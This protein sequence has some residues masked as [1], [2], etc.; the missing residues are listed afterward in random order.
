M[1][2]PDS[3]MT[4][5]ACRAQAWGRVCASVQVG[6][7]VVYLYYRRGIILCQRQQDGDTGG[8]VLAGAQGPHIPGEAR[9]ETLGA[10]RVNRQVFNV[11]SQG[12]NIT[13]VECLKYLLHLCRQQSA[14]ECPVLLATS[15]AVF[16]KST[17][18]WAR[19]AMYLGGIVVEMVMS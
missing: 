1:G 12:F 10:L 9:V 15:L 3:A 18:C 2:P 19:S 4:A 16:R 5:R 11:T 17:L 13:S 7:C 14:N 6:Q 8:Q